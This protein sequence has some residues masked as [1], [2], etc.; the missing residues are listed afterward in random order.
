MAVLSAKGLSFD[1]AKKKVTGSEYNLRKIK[2][3]FPVFLQIWTNC[4]FLLIFS[5]RHW[6]Y[7][8][9]GSF[10]KMEYTFKCKGHHSNFF[11]ILHIPYGMISVLDTWYLCLYLLY[12]FIIC[13]RYLTMILTWSN[14][15]L[16]KI[17]ISQNNEIVYKKSVSNK[18]SC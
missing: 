12:F 3:I 4:M 5:F 1:K 15:N 18:N 14:P 10:L 2:F 6:V 9:K 13:S 11:N 8:K 16:A 7:I 17:N